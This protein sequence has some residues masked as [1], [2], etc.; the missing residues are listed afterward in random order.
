MWFV[1]LLLIGMLCVSV[2]LSGSCIDF[3]VGF[4]SWVWFGH[5]VFVW[6]LMIAGFDC[7]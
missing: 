4:G 2:L 5:L 7:L 6:F 3:G 1:G